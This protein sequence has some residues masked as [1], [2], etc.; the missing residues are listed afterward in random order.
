MIT[1]GSVW[2][3]P[4]FGMAT[5]GPPSSDGRLAGS[6]TSDL[7]PEPA[8]LN[9]PK[10]SRPARMQPTQ[11]KMSLRRL[12]ERRPGALWATSGPTT[13]APTTSSPDTSRP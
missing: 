2:R 11:V 8:G 6:L 3:L 12:T 4:S 1:T 10:A 5:A 13:S 9:S 7:G